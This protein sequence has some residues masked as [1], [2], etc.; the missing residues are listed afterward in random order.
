MAKADEPKT[1]KLVYTASNGD[2][3]TVHVAEE[4]ADSMVGTGAGA[5]S[6]PSRAK[7]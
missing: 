4:V 7:S 1:T 2:E 5:F 6:K 3:I